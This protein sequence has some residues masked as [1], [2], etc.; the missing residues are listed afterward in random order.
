MILIT[1]TLTR[2][3]QNR[4]FTWDLWQKQSFRS[5]LANENPNVT[6][7]CKTPLWTWKSQCNYDANASLSRNLAPAQRHALIA[8]Q[9]DTSHIHEKSLSRVLPNGR[10]IE[11]RFEWLRTVANS[12]TKSG[13]R[14]TPKLNENPSLSI[15]EKHG[16]LSRSMLI[17]RVSS[18]T[19]CMCWRL[20]SHAPKFPKHLS[21]TCSSSSSCL[22]GPRSHKREK[23]KYKKKVLNL[24]IFWSNVK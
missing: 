23:A 19:H 22:W 5:N 17:L 12:K 6:A 8:S 16:G 20:P 15:R 21:L 9:G 1:A 14:R 24:N 13:K 4:R 3:L 18:Y 7:T 2:F 11:I 10:A